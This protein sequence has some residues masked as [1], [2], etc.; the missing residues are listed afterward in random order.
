MRLAARAPGKVNLCL[1]LGPARPDG[2][3]ELGSVL[4][5]VSLADELRLVPG[6]PG[7]PGDVV[8]CAGVE[9]ENLAARALSAYRALTGWA[10]P[11]LR[12]EIDKRVPVAAGMGGGSSDAAAAL[13]LV[14]HAA[15][16]PL[17]GLGAAE[18]DAIEAL[19]FALG[20]DV[21]ALLEPG[22]VAVLGAGERVRPLPPLPPHGILVLPARAR[23]STAEVFA[24]A[25][26]GRIRE[27]GEVRELS[28]RL[29]ESLARG[30]APR[31][32]LVNDLQEPAIALCPAI[33]PALEA[34]LGAGADH[35]LV[36]GSGPTV[37]GL[38]LGADGPSR[39]SAAAEAL[40][41]RDPAPVACGPAGPDRAAPRPVED[42][43]A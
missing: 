29:A 4:E 33:G 27:V 25:D 7:E 9:G 36:S 42:D 1:L 3:H 5:A 26:R 32:L 12:L 20:A 10:G 13:R 30:D 2:R 35:A 22:P 43:R 16:R 17:P 34:A 39:A 11:P 19:A 15:G 41:G 8:V 21:P 6:A 24:Q 14:A 37:F 38:F 40:A 23:L 31:E 28:E 18:R